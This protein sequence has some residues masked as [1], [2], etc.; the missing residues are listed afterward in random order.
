MSCFFKTLIVY[1]ED[2]LLLH[3][4]LSIAKYLHLFLYLSGEKD[5]LQKIKY[6]HGEGKEVCLHPSKMVYISDFLLS[7]FR[8]LAMFI[9]GG[10]F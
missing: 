2:W 3:W 9:M 4:L 5:Y 1:Y 10:D 8:W 7:N 6:F